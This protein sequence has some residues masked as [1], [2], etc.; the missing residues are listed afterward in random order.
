[1]KNYYQKIKINSEKSFG[2]F[3]AIIFFG[4][5][6]WPLINGNSI[7][8]WS[9]FLAIILLIVSLLVPKILRPL[10]FLWF[11]FGLL[12]GTI[13]S[14]IVLA[15]IFFLI[16]TPTSIIMKLFM[17]NFFRLKSEKLLNSYWEKYDEKK[18]TMKNQF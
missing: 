16:V 11:K 3:F 4:I 10:N 12:L 9:L 17:N 13:V 8:Y 15:V 14:K 2:L 5:S 6:F 1:M 7:R 18:D